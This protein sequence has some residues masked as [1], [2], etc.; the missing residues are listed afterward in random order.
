MM[1]T[2]NNEYMIVNNKV[3]KK[4]N[5]LFYELPNELIKLLKE[6]NTDIKIND[7]ENEYINYLKKINVLKE[8]DKYYNPFVK[9]SSNNKVRLFIQLT[10]DCNLNCKHCFQGNE[11]NLGK[12]ML[13]DDVKLLIIEAV[14]KGIYSMD[15][16]GGEIFTLNYMKNLLNFLSDF[17]IK[18]NLFT[19]LSFLSNDII[20]SIQKF[21]GLDNII[22][23]L[24]YFREGKHDD[25]RGK[26]GSFS[27]T[28]KKHYKTKR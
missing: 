17:P 19:N 10:E 27:S 16:T 3:I 24:D 13:Y 12:N 14:K 8:S 28:I 9:R 25:F 6:H 5:T 22:T 21:K 1:L 15:F 11:K 7:I 2:F 4:D 20:D 18:S 26:R 23:S